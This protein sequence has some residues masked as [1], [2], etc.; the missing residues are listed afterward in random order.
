MN[1]CVYS[2]LHHAFLR[3]VD[4]TA[5]ATIKLTIHTFTRDDDVPPTSAE[6]KKTLR[7]LSSSEVEM[8]RYI[9]HDLLEYTR[10]SSRTPIMKKLM[11]LGLIVELRLDGDPM[12]L[13]TPFGRDVARYL[14]E[15]RKR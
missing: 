5:F 8:L 1:F 3:V 6:I 7:G 13:C 15:K 12:F 14:A 9:Y 2:I 4:V 10:R 11:H